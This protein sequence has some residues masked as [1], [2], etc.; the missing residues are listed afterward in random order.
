[1]HD[2]LKEQLQR[3][4]VEAAILERNDR[5]NV[6]FAEVPESEYE[7]ALSRYR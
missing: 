2:F 6:A 4:V 5:S 1:L 7:A 3:Y